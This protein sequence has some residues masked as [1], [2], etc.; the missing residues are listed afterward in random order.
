[1]PKVSV[2]MP[3]Y[4][5][6]KYVGDAIKSILKQSYVDFEL[7]LVDDGSTDKS[8]DIC[9]KYAAKDERV[10]VI[11]QKNQGLCAARNCGLDKATGIYIC[12]VDNDDYCYPSY[13]K[14]NI[15][16][17]LKY[18]ADVVRFDRLRIQTFENSS[19]I[20]KD[21]SGTRGIV[22]E[23]NPVRVMK[24][25]E[26]LENYTKIKRSGAMYGIWNAMFKRSFIEENQLRFCTK[27]KYGGE[28]GLLNLQ[29]IQHAK[30]YVFHKGVYYR[31]AIGI[32]QIL[33]QKN[34]DWSIAKKNHYLNYLVE[35]SV[36]K[37]D[38]FKYYLKDVYKQNAMIGIFASLFYRKKFKMCCALIKAYEMFDKIKNKR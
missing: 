13:I 6:E 25:H 38:D 22:D 18:D 34:S 5:S 26:I 8:G 31:Y 2:I 4:N 3:V 20:M 35:E 36:L 10:K 23:K 12:F 21:I 9:E 33:L 17:A 32:M 30:C 16:L 29:A 24:D 7:I 37:N 14:D 15:E 28:D 19:K 11:H 1:M 27:I